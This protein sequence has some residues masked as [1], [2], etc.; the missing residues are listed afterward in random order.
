MLDIISS[1][2]IESRDVD[3]PSSDGNPMRTELDTMHY[4]ALVEDDRDCWTFEVENHE[5]LR[6]TFVWEEVP[7]DI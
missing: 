5:L 3:E 4:G 2:D 1:E 6:I 7:D